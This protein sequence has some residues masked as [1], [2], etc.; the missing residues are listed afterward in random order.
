MAIRL[1]LIVLTAAMVVAVCAR[2]VPDQPTSTMVVADDDA[3]DDAI[4]PPGQVVIA[5]FERESHVAAIDPP[6]SGGR[7]HVA[8]LFRPPR[9]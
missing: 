3:T 7:V 4:A 8:S 1:V 9:P 6:M 2:L 5:R